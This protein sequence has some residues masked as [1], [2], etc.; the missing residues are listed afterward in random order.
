M[1]CYLYQAVYLQMQTFVQL[2]EKFR[3]TLQ[4]GKLDTP[5]AK[6]CGP[7]SRNPFTV[8]CWLLMHGAVWNGLGCV[9]GRPCA[10]CYKEG[11]QTQPPKPSMTDAAL[12]FWINV[13]CHLSKSPY[14][15][16]CHTRLGGG[17]E[18]SHQLLHFAPS[19]QSICN[20]TVVFET[21]RS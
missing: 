7:E 12:G 16:Y 10:A 2:P 9:W 6:L 11:P 8:P 5:L 15:R 18:L 1:S 19:G 4:Q 13:D 17:V 20:C 21:W 14:S 3:Q